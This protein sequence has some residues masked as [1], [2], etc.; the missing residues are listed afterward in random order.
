MTTSELIDMAMQEFFSLSAV[1]ADTPNIL[2]RGITQPTVVVNKNT[3]PYKQ[4]PTI[5]DLDSFK[6]T[7]F[8]DAENTISYKYIKNIVNL[9][10]TD[11]GY[12]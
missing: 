8:E 11:G 9:N 5:D 7:T 10:K 2:F 4:D 1:V 6:I 12:F 3:Q